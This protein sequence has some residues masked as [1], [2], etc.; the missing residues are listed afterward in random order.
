M[1]KKKPIRVRGY[2]IRTQ[3]EGRYAG[4]D[5]PTLWAPEPLIPA[6]WAAVKR[7]PRVVRAI[8]F[9]SGK[10]FDTYTRC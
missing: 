5:G 8:L 3:Y 2:R 7:D 4:C 10:K 6:Q 1:Q 9:R